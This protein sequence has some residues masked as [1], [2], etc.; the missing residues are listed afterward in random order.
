M[1]ISSKKI[2]AARL[3]ALKMASKQLYLHVTTVLAV[4]SHGL[5]RNVAFRIFTEKYGITVTCNWKEW[6]IDKYLNGGNEF[7]K[8]GNRTKRYKP[9]ITKRTIPTVKH[10][11]GKPYKVFLK[12]KYWQSVRVVVLKRDGNKC[13]RCENT[14]KL[15]VHHTTYV[16]HFDEHNHLEDLITLCESCHEKEH[17]I[18]K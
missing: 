12:S 14:E 6:L 4:R 13:T 8:K 16:N 5:K 2:K 7:I 9:R 10:L 17:N 15:H 11:I 3:H 18:N 1:T